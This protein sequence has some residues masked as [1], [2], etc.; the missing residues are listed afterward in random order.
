MGAP[1]WASSLVWVD[2]FGLVYWSGCF[3]LV[4]LVFGAKDFA[5][6]L[7]HE[8]V[9]IMHE[10]IEVKSSGAQRSRGTYPQ[11]RKSTEGNSTPVETFLFLVFV[12]CLYYQKTFS[13]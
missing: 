2:L 3:S 13:L 9:Y 6:L 11:N 5:A 8:I 7:K 4:W 10:W 1:G 12:F